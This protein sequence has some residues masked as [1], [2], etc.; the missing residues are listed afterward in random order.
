VSQRVYIGSE[1]WP[2]RVG[3]ARISLAHQ[4]GTITCERCGAV[5]GPGAAMVMETN[6]GDDTTFQCGACRPEVA[7]CPGLVAGDRAVR[8]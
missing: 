2:S 7:R 6:A 3:G 4:H 1:S 8:S 5:M